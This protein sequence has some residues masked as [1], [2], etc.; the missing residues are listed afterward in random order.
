[1]S[2]WSKKRAI[3]RMERN[4]TL[5]EI[6]KTEPRLLPILDQAKAQQ[7]GKGY[8]RIAVYTNLRNQAAG[9]VGSLAEKEAVRAS[10]HY[11]IVIQTIADL[12]PP[13]QSDRSD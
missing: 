13:D 5:Q 4:H 7:G 1:M 11:D 8:D 10:V 2:K 3:E 6:L 12:L 9:L